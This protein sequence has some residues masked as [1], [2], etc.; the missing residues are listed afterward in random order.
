M[1]VENSQ[2]GDMIPIVRQNVSSRRRGKSGDN[3]LGVG[4]G[5]EGEDEEEGLLDLERG[6]QQDSYANPYAALNLN[7]PPL[8]PPLDDA[9]DAGV[10]KLG[11]GGGSGGAS[12]FVLRQE[13]EIAPI[14]SYHNLVMVQ[15]ASYLVFQVHYNWYHIIYSFKKLNRFRFFVVGIVGWVLLHDFVFCPSCCKLY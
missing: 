10:G 12:S 13:Q 8:P 2:T 15:R 5:D 4:G 14:V 6:Q 7:V 11:S 1:W 9:Q 3:S